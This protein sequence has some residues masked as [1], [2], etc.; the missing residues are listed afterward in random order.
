MTVDDLLYA[1]RH[2]LL[3]L[4]PQ[5]IARGRTWALFVTPNLDGGAVVVLWPMARVVATLGLVDDLESAV[6]N[7]ETMWIGHDRIRVIASAPGE[8]VQVIVMELAKRGDPK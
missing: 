4:A 6:V 3:S 5:A 7:G 8:P 2:D 1:A